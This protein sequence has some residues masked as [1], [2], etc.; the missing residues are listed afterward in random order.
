MNKKV[1]RKIFLRWQLYLM[2]LPVLLYKILFNYKPMYG[3]LIAFKD[4][5][6]KNG[7]WGSEWVG[8][9]NFERL[10][11]SYTFPIALKNTLIISFLNLILNFPLPIILALSMNEIR[12]S[13]VKRLVQTVSYAPHFISTVVMCGM[14]ILFL[15]PSHGII[16]QMIVFLGGEKISF[17]QE[18]H[19]FKWIYNLSGVWQ[20]AGWG[21]I[22]YLSALAGVDKALLE[23]AEMDGASRFQRVRH[24]NLPTIIPTITIMLILDCGHLLSLGYAKVLLLQNSANLSASEVLSTYVYKMGLENFDYSFSTAANIF[25]SVCNIILL[26]TVNKIANKINN[27]GL[28]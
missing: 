21:T 13:K 6:L 8:F 28:W 5:K 20:N 9:D 11:L 23:A 24:I 19:M 18:P 22:I 12:N 2:I 3:V 25:N 4:F 14:V 1:M 15:S 17:M 7:I 16:N 27:S 10:F 26:L